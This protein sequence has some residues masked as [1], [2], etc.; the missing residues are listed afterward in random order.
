MG[1][2]CAGNVPAVLGSGCGV[3]QHPCTAERYVWVSHGAFAAA[4]AGQVY[5]LLL[6]H[7]AG[8]QPADMWG[9]P[10][11][12]VLGITS[13]VQGVLTFLCQPAVGAWSDVV[14]RKWALF[15]SIVSTGLPVFMLAFT[16]SMWVYQILY[17]LSG[18]VNASYSLGT[19]HGC[20][21][22]SRLPCAHLFAL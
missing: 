1:I 3:F 18:F 12:L 21:S 7:T 17:G 13:G 20:S 10:Q 9:V 11:Y 14:G 2:R 6:L 22:H 15:A 4:M 8:P 16:Q 5:P 19:L